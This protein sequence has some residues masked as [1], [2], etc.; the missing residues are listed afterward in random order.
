[1]NK[2]AMQYLRD[3]KVDIGKDLLTRAERTL[4]NMEDSQNAIHKQ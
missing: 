3:G 4:L 1:M 2:N